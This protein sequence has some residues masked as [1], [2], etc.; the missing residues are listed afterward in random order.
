[1]NQSN[2]IKLFATFSKPLCIS[3]RVAFYCTKNK[4]SFYTLYKKGFW[5]G[6]KRKVKKIALQEIE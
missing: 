5:T 1:L 3:C 6:K 4:E 2:K